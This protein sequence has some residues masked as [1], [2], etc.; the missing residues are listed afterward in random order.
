[1]PDFSAANVAPKA[2]IIIIMTLIHPWVLIKV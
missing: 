1:M 2:I